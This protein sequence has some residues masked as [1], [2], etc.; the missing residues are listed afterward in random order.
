[1]NNV[2]IRDM[3]ED[4]AEE[5]LG[6]NE[7]NLPHVSSISPK[8]FDHLQRQACYFRIAEVRGKIAGFLLAF[9]PEADYGSLNFLWFKERY[10]AFVYIDR[11]IIAPVARRKGIASCLYNDLERFACM[12]QIPLM[13]CEYNLLP[14]NEESRLF[15]LKYGFMEA[16]TQK[17]DHGKK[18]VSLQVKQVNRA[19]LPV[20]KDP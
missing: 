16:G 6:L 18:T 5:L 3:H 8:D 20:S 17:T 1:M 19:G 4:D 7:A 10:P 12:Q 13:T 9:D 2:H 11:I 15:H 14:K